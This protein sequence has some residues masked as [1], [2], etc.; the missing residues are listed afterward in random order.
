MYVIDFGMSKRW[1]DGYGKH[2]PS[3]AKKRA[4][5]VS[6]LV[7][8][9]RFCSI[10][11]HYGDGLSRRDDLESLCFMIS[12]LGTG[13]LPWFDVSKKRDVA[14]AHLQI[15]QKKEVAKPSELFHGLPGAYSEIMRTVREMAREDDPPYDLFVKKLQK[16]LKSSVKTSGKQRLDWL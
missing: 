13:S 14:S 10:S 3:Q 15:L 11:A 1:K 7:G 4:T 5:G 16:V 12:F 9:P 6:H 8:T 2:V